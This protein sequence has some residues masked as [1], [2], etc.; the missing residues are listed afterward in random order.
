MNERHFNNMIYYFYNHYNSLKEANKQAI[1]LRKSGGL[2]R[3]THESVG[4]SV[5][6]VVWDRLPQYYRGKKNG[7]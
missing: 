4:Y 5:G 1:S 2:A 6:Y 7:R 3:V